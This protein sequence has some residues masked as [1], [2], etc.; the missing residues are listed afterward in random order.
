LDSDDFIHP[1]TLELLYNNI[2]ANSS[3]MAIYKL[4]GYDN[5]THETK[6][7]KAFNL[8]TVFGDKDFSDFTFTYK[9][10]KDYVLTNLCSTCLK[11]YDKRFIDKHDCFRFPEGISFEDIPFHVKTMLLAT[12][13]SFVPEYLYYYRVNPLSITHD[14]TKRFDI[15]QIIDMVESF[16]EE[17]GYIDEFKEEFKAYKVNRI[18]SYLISTRSE[19]FF[20]KA[21]EEF[22]GIDID[23]NSLLDD[24]SFEN[25]TLVL[26]SPSYL[27]FIFN[28]Y[29][30]KIK[31]YSKKQ[32]KPLRQE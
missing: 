5:E 12:K 4:Y 30:N 18:F 20:Q 9:Q 1:N 27:D 31:R 3:D 13:L 24:F 6:K 22:S 29:D 8:E 10:V 26:D 17:N 11:L 25:Y 2:V 32:Q 15:F 28:F 14:P 16:L 7:S 19:E 21:K 23:E